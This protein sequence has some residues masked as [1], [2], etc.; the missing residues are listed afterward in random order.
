MYLCSFILFS[1]LSFWGFS[2]YRMQIC[3]GFKNFFFLKPNLEFQLVFT[4]T[5]EIDWN[6]L[7]FFQSGIGKPWTKI[8]KSP[9]QPRPQVYWIPPP[10]DTSK[11]NFD[12]AIFKDANQ[13]RIGVIIRDNRGLV[14]ESMSQKFSLPN[15]VDDIEAMQRLLNP[16]W[17]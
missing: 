6:N 1:F 3:F 4:K 5:P 2:V 7:K 10:N 17:I 15:S 9:L 8:L 12:E 14:I 13:E 16:L 11:I